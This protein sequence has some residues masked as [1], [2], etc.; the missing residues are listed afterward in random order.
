[1]GFRHNS[2]RIH[3]QVQARAIAYIPLFS[4][5][6]LSLNSRS[7]LIYLAQAKSVFTGKFKIKIK[8]KNELA[9]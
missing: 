2:S 8:L 7:S 6:S 9:Q 3:E 5:S 4:E 1:M